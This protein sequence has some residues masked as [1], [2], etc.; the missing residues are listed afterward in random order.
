MR[1]PIKI[2]HVCWRLGTGAKYDKLRNEEGDSFQLPKRMEDVCEPNR[3]Q[4][5]CQKL[6]PRTTAQHANI[7]KGNTKPGEAIFDFVSTH[8]RVSSG[9][10]A[11]RSTFAT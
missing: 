10:A 7:E 4:K 9:A 1:Q 11:D 5:K 8:G 3:Q 6:H 2:S